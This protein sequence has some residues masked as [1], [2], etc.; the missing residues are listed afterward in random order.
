[1]KG[2]RLKDLTDKFVTNRLAIAKAIRDYNAM[3]PARFVGEAAA[4]LRDSADHAGRRFLLATLS[5]RPDF[6]RILC[7]Q[8]YFSAHETAALIRQVKAI[9][10]RIEMRLAQMIATLGDHSD[11]A[12][13]FA[14]HCL[15]VLSELS[16]DA[17]SLPALRELLSSQNARIRSKAALLIGHISRNPQWAKWNDIKNDPRVAANAVE[18]IWGLD[19]DAAKAV[20]REAVEFPQPRQAINGAVGLY[21]AREIEAVTLLFRFARHDDFHFRASAAWGMG[22]TGDPRFLAI[23]ESLKQEREDPVRM[24]AGRALTVLRQRVESLKQVPAIPV[25]IPVSKFR[26]GEHTVQVALGEE[27][28]KMRLDALHFAISNGPSPVEEFSF[29]QLQPTDGPLYEC[30]FRGP[31]TSTRM[32]KVELFTNHG[33]GESTGFELS[34]AARVPITEFVRKL[35]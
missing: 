10:P 6:L 12:T 26:T 32:V 1:M 16:G 19:S 5:M 23:L 11:T 15:E 21:L 25:H 17:A 34:D 35:V 9:D 3:D 2:E 13:A 22:R 31:Q 28:A 18:S 8:N 20:F 33:C 14:A 27:A 29:A 24:A 7:D 4:I 30:R